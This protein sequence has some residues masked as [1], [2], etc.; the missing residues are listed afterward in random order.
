MSLWKGGSA[1]IYMVVIGLSWWNKAQ[2]M[3]CD[4]DTWIMVDDL[5][6]VIHQ[7][8]ETHS[9]YLTGTKR[10][11]KGSEENQR[12]TKRGTYYF[13]YMATP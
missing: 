9:S 5:K 10:V 7:M 8:Y 2:D 11:F 13:P 6:W 4:A 12:A 3:K 1:G